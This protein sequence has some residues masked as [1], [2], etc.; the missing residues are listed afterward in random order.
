MYAQPE[1]GQIVKVRARQYLVEEVVPPQVL[2]KGECT[3]VRLACLEDDAQGE[4]LEVFWERELDAE[5]KGG[6]AW[7]DV[8][9]LGFDPPER[10][11]AYLHT[12]RWNCVTST[13]ARFFQAPYRAGIDIKTYQLEPL[14]KAL[15]LPRVNL[16]IADDVG[17][18]KTIEAGL[19]VRELIQ[20]QKVRRIVVAVPP[21][22]VIQWK[23]ELENRF[24][25]TFEVLDRSY[26]D[27]IRRER[28]WST[29]PWS[30]HSRFIVSHAILRDEAYATPLRDWLGTF[31]PGSLLIL[32]EAHHA[33]PAS[34]ARYAVDSRFT[35][36][37]REV[38]RCCVAVPKTPLVASSLAPKPTPPPVTQ[39]E[40]AFRSGAPPRVHRPERQ[41][42]MVCRR[43]FSAFRGL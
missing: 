16:F 22:V 19:I 29:N 39:P 7:S 26:V 5:V 9:R 1:P 36:V 6:T 38:A 17:L 4:P 3:L 18:G 33:A 40:V 24:G 23:E 8:A 41:A 20:R 43:A 10:F 11:S 27:R 31:S 42:G 13:D 25:L 28:G 14:R 35:K 30:T 15:A 37:V 32:D 21:S 2:R 34:G 12:L